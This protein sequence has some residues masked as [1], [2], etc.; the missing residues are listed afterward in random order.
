MG[1]VEGISKYPAL[2]FLATFTIIL[3]LIPVARHFFL[4]SGE[5]Q[6]DIRSGVFQDA[7][8]DVC[9][10]AEGRPIV[11]YFGTSWCPHCKFLKTPFDEAVGTFADKSLI[12][13]HDWGEMNE[14][15][16]LTLEDAAI[17]DNFSDGGSVP[18]IVI[19]C[20]YYRVGSPF[21]YCANNGAS[22]E[23]ESITRAICRALPEGEPA[24]AEPEPLS[25]NATK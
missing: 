16:K 5:A 2:A 9:R 12:E 22:L 23:K 21:E 25:S 14:S 7:G 10:D 13:V 15:T 1:V 20:R 17:F 11:H 3:V 6:C 19:G 18:T 8:G 4:Q 24:C